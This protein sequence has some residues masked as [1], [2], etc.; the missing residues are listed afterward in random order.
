MRENPHELI[1]E[2]PE[3]I[4]AAFEDDDKYMIS[5]VCVMPFTARF[6]GSDTLMYGIGGVNTLPA[7]R[8]GGCVR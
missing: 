6:D 4:W 7:Y 8:R 1:D 2:H 5:S 3:F